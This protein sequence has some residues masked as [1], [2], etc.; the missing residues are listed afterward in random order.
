[1]NDT[2]YST[3]S[4]NTTNDVAVSVFNK[5][6]KSILKISLVLLLF[7]MTNYIN[8]LLIAVFFKHNVFHENS[9]YILFIHMVF[10]D[11]LDICTVLILH[12]WV[13]TLHMMPVSLC[14][15]LM[16]V[17]ITTTY[18]TPLNLALM[19]IERYIAICRPLHHPKICTL[20][21]TYIILIMMWLISFISP[22]SDILFVFTVEPLS[23]FSTKTICETDS[24]LR[25]EA[26]T[27]KRDYM[28]IGYFLVAWIVVALT[29]INIVLAAR[30]ASR[31]EKSP[32]KKAYN[33]ILLHAIQLTLSTFMFLVPVVNNLWLYFQK[34]ESQD[35]QYVSYVS[36]VM[37]PRLL[38]PLIYGVREENFKKYLKEYLQ[39][40]KFAKNS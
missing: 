20:H 23:F 36:I 28:S 24:L 21:R 10:N 27:M 40:W 5:Q 3:E 9:R 39:C 8:G 16:S 12:I 13:E 18:N 34:Q 29:Y 38:S 17:A 22:A 31:A 15:F 26:Q 25:T 11:V 30:S 2:E 4:N 32:A 7:I 35:V 19:A 37:F 33:T 14:Y 1:M 6:I